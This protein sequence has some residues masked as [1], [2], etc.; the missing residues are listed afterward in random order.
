MGEMFKGVEVGKGCGMHVCFKVSNQHQGTPDGLD[1][2]GNFITVKRRELSG[3]LAM[4]CLI[5]CILHVI[6]G[7][8]YMHV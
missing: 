8:A 7:G 2:D 1:G 6:W 5:F 4:D 3:N